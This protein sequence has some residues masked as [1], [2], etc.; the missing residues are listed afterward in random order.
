MLTLLSSIRDMNLLILLCEL[1]KYTF[2]TLFGLFGTGS[3]KTMIVLFDF[4]IIYSFF[5][6][7]VELDDF[8]KVAQRISTYH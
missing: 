8:K 2:N 5:E 7:N 1:L 4:L 6:K 3:Y